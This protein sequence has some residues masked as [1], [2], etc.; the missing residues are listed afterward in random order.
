MPTNPPV[1]DGLATDTAIFWADRS[2][3]WREYLTETEATVVSDL[4][5]RI[6]VARLASAET[7]AVLNPIR[8]RA[9]HRAKYQRKTT[10]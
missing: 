10:S 8:N 6:Q 3:P 7:V 2:S 1:K 4:E 9:I 5:R